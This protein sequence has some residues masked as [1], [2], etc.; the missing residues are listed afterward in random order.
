MK[1]LVKPSPEAWQTGP[2]SRRTPSLR[3]RFLRSCNIY[4]RGTSALQN[5]SI[6]IQRQHTGRSSAPVW[7]RSKMFGLLALAHL[8]INLAGKFARA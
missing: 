7:P 1:P 5:H 6:C 3:I 2:K 8:L 4:L